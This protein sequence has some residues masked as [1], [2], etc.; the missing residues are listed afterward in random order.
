MK[1][2]HPVTLC[3]D[4]NLEECRRRLIESVDPER[5]TFLSLSGYKGSKPIIGRFEGN[6]FCLHKRRY[7]R[8]DFA[9][10]FYGSLV[11]LPRGTRVEGYFDARRDAKLSMRIWLAIAI[12]IGIPLFV[13]SLRDALLK[14]RSI[15]GNLWVGL[16]VPSALVLFGIVLPKFGL[17]LGRG[18]ER[19]ILALLES[20]LVATTVSANEQPTQFNQT[21][22]RT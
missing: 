10:R 11:S 2:R 12:L 18:E 7:Y 22:F 5:W 16:L 3:T 1:L 13:E 6:A 4:F 9:P 14:T 15:E 8:N 21:Q 19:S 17:W 20:T